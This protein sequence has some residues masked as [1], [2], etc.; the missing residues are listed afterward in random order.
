MGFPARVGH[1]EGMSF[2]SSD[3]ATSSDV[4]PPVAAARLTAHEARQRLEHERGS[5]LTQLRALD[6]AGPETDEHLKAAQRE[7]LERVL[8][9]IDAAFGRVQDGSYGTCMS[10]AKPIPA[11]RLEI[12]PY[13]RFCVACQRR[14]G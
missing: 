5:R 7:A 11:E 13:V 8:G 10:C 1:G 4:A 2:E 14:A 6:E 3:T 9:E 12:L